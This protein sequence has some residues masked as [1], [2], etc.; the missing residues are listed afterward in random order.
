MAGCIE[1]RVEMNLFFFFFA[2]NH[3]LL[4]I[5][6]EE[7]VF[8]MSFKSNKKKEW[9]DWGMGGK[10]GMRTQNIYTQSRRIN[11]NKQINCSIEKYK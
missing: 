2:K 3:I 11:L 6:I 4:P 7:D 5:R 9:S 10:W 8:L 1:Q